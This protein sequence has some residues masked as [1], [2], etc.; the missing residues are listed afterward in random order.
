MREEEEDEEE[1]KKKRR[2]K[3]GGIKPRYGTIWFCMD[4]LSRYMF[5]GCGW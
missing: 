1:E 3:E 5:L 4:F 2:E